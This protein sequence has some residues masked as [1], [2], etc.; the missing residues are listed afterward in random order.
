MI[1]EEI[2]RLKEKVAQLIEKAKGSGNSEMQWLWNSI[3]SFSI[4]NTAELPER[5]E[6]TIPPRMQDISAVLS[7]GYYD[8]NIYAVKEFTVHKAENEYPVTVFPSLQYM[9]ALKVLNVH[10]DTSHITKIIQSTGYHAA[11]LETMNGIL[12][13]PLVFG[14]AAVGLSN[15]FSYLTALKEVRFAE[16][17]IRSSVS[18]ASAVLT[19]ES[20]QSIIDG[21]A[22]VT[23]AQTLTLH[24]TVKNKLTEEQLAVINE[25][26]WT[27]A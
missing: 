5:L 2:A 22:E 17:G 23:S 9:S 14:N 7:H 18:F 19:D 3:S 12:N 6:I 25:K 21:I 8:T 13:F 1:G 24:E 27:L 26:G 10:F 4:S 20:I 11:A 16:N 15:L